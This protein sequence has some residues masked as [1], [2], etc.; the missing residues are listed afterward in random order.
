MD[1]FCCFCLERVTACK[2]LLLVG[3]C[4]S[5]FFLSAVGAQGKC[6]IIYKSKSLK[7]HYTMAKIGPN[8]SKD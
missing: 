1:P 3:L 2:T 7:A 8:L 4:T 6:H 5:E